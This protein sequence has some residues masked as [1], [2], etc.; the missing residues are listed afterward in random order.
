MNIFKVFILKIIIQAYPYNS[1]LKGKK[2][3]KFS[4][5]TKKI[6]FSKK[7]KKKKGK[8]C[9]TRE[10]GNQVEPTPFPRVVGLLLDT[11]L[12]SPHDGHSDR[13]LGTATPSLHSTDHQ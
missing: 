9:R 11:V 12:T 6:T 7:E 2:K 10:L 8:C 5:V 13:S 4:K 3:S 1:I